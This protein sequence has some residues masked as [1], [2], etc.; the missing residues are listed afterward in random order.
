MMI[1]VLIIGCIEK[2]PVRGGQYFTYDE[3]GNFTER[4]YDG[5]QFAGSRFILTKYQILSNLN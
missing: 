3:T 4:Y 5:V 1:I 2:E